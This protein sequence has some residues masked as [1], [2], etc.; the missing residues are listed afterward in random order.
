MSSSRKQYFGVFTDAIGGESLF[1][2][3]CNECNAAPGETHKDHCEIAYCA[4][5]G[6]FLDEPTDPDWEQPC[7]PGIF[8][9]YILGEIEAITRNW[10][11]GLDSN[12]DF[13]YPDFDRVYEELIWSEAVGLFVTFDILSICLPATFSPDQFEGQE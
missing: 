13:P 11:L 1:K 8:T 9:G 12:D 3:I 10:W 2:Y 4:T 7:R 6:H 5:H